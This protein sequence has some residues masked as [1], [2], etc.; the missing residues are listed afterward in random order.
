[1]QVAGMTD[2]PRLF[3]SYSHDDEAHKAWVL[4]LATR[5]VKNG[6]DVILD[7]WDIKLG[8]DLSAFME[9]GLTD[10]DR[11][12]AVCS[13]GYV[14]KANAGDGGVGYE[15][16]I[17]TSQLMRN[18]NTHRIIP[19]IRR[20][21]LEEVRPVFLNTRLFVDFRDDALYE[22]KYG[23]MLRDIHG[24]SIAP[25]PPLGPNPFT[26]AVSAIEP[27]LSFSLERYVSP[28]NSGTVTFDYSNNNGRYAVGSGDMLFETAWSGGS[29]TSI[30]AYTDPPSIRSV[31]LVTDKRDIRAIADAAFY[32]T[33][34]RVR[35][36]HLGQIAVWQNTQG[37][38]LATKVLSLK[39][40]SHG[41]DVDE[42]SFEY[43]VASHKTADFRTLNT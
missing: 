18:V 35:S 8:S 13:E 36:P 42:I 9:R 30:H 21:T 32:D 12:M 10:A 31:A 19:V 43:E 2:A 28:A 33:S 34:S 38:Y 26:Q 37:Y 4:Q 15:K 3:I 41:S 24:I 7:Q 1:M 17:L 27:R 22:V 39:S 25:R 29:N 40:R 6:V 20:N 11:I 14:V 23:E 16:T 5:L